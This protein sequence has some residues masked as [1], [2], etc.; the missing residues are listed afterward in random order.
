MSMLL[1][2]IL[3]LFNMLLAF[4]IKMIVN[5]KTER[6]Y[7]SSK[8]VRWFLLIPPVSIV[9]FFSMVVFGIFYTIYMALSLY[10]SND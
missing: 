4:S 2:M 5:D 1:I 6:K 8:W 7:L 9:L 3:F 10:L